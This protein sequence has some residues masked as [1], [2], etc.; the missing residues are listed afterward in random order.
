MTALF[1]IGTVAKDLVAAV[2]WLLRGRYRLKAVY[3][4]WA[5]IGFDALPMVIIISLIA[6]M[7]L[8]LQTADKFAQTGA[9]GYVGGVVSLAFVREMGPIFT[10]LAVGAQCGT[11]MAAELAHMAVTEQLNAL[12]VLRIS[13]IRHLL[14]PRLLGCML[15]LPMLTVIGTLTGILGGMFTVRV[16]A[17]LHYSKFLE[18][19]WLALRPFDVLSGLMKAAVFGVIMAGIA[20]SVGLNA[21]GGAEAVG[22]ATTQT[23][24][25]TAIGMMV[26][27]FFMTWTLFAPT[28]EVGR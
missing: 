10:C 1:W 24:V 25:W 13:P 9:D 12:K 19:A 20:G 23:A 4:Q 18:S 8:S 16:T 28:A 15:S 14:L 5:L 21:R 6:G 27:D 17:H 26:A 11:A 3:Q 22:K 2:G 7:V